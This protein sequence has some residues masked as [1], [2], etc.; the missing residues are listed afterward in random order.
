VGDVRLVVRGPAP[1][2]LTG[3]LVADTL[4]LPLAGWLRPEPGLA[5]T[6]ERG[7]PPAASGRG[8]LATLCRDLLDRHPIARAAA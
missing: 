3:E 4:G 7:D 6:L 1:A 2:G 8:P 5:R